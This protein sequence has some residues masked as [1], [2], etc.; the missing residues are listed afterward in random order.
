MSMTLFRL[1]AFTFRR[2][3]TIGVMCGWWGGG[4]D[5]GPTRQAID[6]ED[7]AHDRGHDMAILDGNAEHGGIQPTGRAFREQPG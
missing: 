1:I 2:Y 3:H 7:T 4:G 5:G 6:Q